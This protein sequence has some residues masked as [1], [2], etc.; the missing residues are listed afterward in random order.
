MPKPRV[1]RA[2]R[3][4]LSRLS[5][6][7]SGRSG[8][9]RLEQ[10]VQVDDEIAH[11]GVVDAR[12]GLCLPSRIG[13]GVVRIDADEVEPGEVLEAHAREVRELAAEDEVEELLLR[14]RIHVEVS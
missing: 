11:L 10:A 8:R 2:A 1:S 7:M 4:R 5:H 6:S 9:L 3:V 14:L 13:A 12:L